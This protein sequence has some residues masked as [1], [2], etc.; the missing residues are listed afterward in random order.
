[1]PKT[2]RK[3]KRRD[4]KVLL[5]AYG[6]DKESA[7]KDMMIKNKKHKTTS[8]AKWKANPLYWDLA[9]GSKVDYLGSKKRVSSINRAVAYKKRKR[10]V[11]SK[12][13]KPR[14]YKR[15]TTT[16]I[17]SKA[18]APSQATIDSAVK[19]GI[20]IKKKKRNSP[21]LVMKSDGELRYQINARLYGK[22][23]A[24]EMR[25]TTSN[26]MS[27]NKFRINNI[28]SGLTHLGA[29]PVKNIPAVYAINK[30]P[31]PKNKPIGYNESRPT[32]QLN[33]DGYN[34]NSR[35]APQLGPDA[36]GPFKL[37]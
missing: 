22:K 14:V 2:S 36:F 13:R 12:P 30:A 18:V 5:K 26:V 37:A 35:P 1:M 6:G 23:K 11:A 16:P 4:Y 7:N 15:S 21:R 33:P 20:G 32:P 28:T 9:K 19:L 27:N 8:Y 3:V 34:T 25:K 17:L 31:P 29:P 24:S 10:T